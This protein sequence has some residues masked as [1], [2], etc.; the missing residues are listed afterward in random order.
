MENQLFRKE[1]TIMKQKLALALSALLLGSYAACKAPGPSLSE[2]NDGL[3][4]LV[5]NLLT[6]SAAEAKKKTKEEKRK[7]KEEKQ[8][9]KQRQAHYIYLFSDDGFNYYLDG[10]ISCHTYPPVG[11]EK[12]IDVWIKVLPIGVAPET[13]VL[14]DQ[15]YYL[16]HYLLYPKKDQIMF[17]SELEVDG[18][19]DNDIQERPYDTRNW[20]NLIPGSLEENI[21][22]ECMK[23]QKKLKQRGDKKS[24]VK[25]AGDFL[26]DT[27]RISL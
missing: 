27:F 4:T 2:E 25:T 21:Y 20:E 3:T 10:E 18:R 26:E 5:E 17:L 19:P 23:R 14:S 22:R 11:Y 15:A 24:A 9:E 12:L 7:E 8:K 13:E 1:V 16:Q 6:P